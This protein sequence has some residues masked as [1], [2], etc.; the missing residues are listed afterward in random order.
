[1]FIVLVSPV[2]MEWGDAT[3]LAL[4]HIILASHN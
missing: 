3:Q 1:M 4:I 2:E